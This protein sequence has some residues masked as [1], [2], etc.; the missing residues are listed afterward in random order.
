MDDGHCPSQD[1][2][3]SGDCLIFLDLMSARTGWRGERE[4]GVLCYAVGYPS[5]QGEEE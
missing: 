4:T 3:L 2:N 5:G 1:R